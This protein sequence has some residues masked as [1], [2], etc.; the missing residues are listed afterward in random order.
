MFYFMFSNILITNSFIKNRIE[1]FPHVCKFSIVF[2]PRNNLQLRGH[3]DDDKLDNQ[4]SLD[5]ALQGKQSSLETNLLAFR[6][7]HDL[8]SH[9]ST[10]NNNAS[11]TS[12]SI[13]ND[14]IE[15]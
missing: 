7:D 1:H 11:T 4:D 15:W 14:I 13:Q 8:K 9:L 3:C 6:I 10:C 5:K 12:K 2:C